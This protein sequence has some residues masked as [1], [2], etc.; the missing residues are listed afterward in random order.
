[1][2][3]QA[4]WQRVVRAVRMEHGV[5]SEIG[6]DSAATVQAIVVAGAA[7]LISGLSALWP[8]GERFRFFGWIVGAAVAATLGL[9][10]G[11]GIL[12]LIS[13]L[14]GATGTFE[15]LFRGLGFATAPNAL[16]IIPFIGGIAGLIWSIV[17]AIRAVKETQSVT[18][19]K[20]V[21]IVLIPAAI[22][23]VIGILLVILA[24]IALLGFAAAD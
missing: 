15:S 4:L 19:G 23:F 13:R 21:A 17:L 2:D 16:G 5:Y 24:G 10:I 8:G 18:D 12:W 11:T 6:S 9:A 20:A 3:F 1:M 14:F 7:S 22:A